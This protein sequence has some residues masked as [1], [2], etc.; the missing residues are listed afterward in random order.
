MIRAPLGASRF[1]GND[2]YRIIE[3]LQEPALDFELPPATGAKPQLAAAEQRHHRRVA[4]QDS[5]FAVIRRRDN[6]I[7]LAFEE[8][9]L[10]RN[11]RNFKHASLTLHLLGFFDD[12]VDS[13]LHVESLL[14]ILVELAGDETLE[15]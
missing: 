9:R 1:F 3:D 5:N 14:R 2:P 12:A 13:A 8:N 11:Q 10:R 4:G 7:G 6:G 15:R